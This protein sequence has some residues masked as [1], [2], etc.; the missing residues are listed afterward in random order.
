MCFNEK[1]SLF[2]YLTGLS[3]S[4]ALFSINKIPESL[5]YGWVVHMQLIEYFLWKN[6]P[7][8]I[9][10]Q[11]KI[12]KAEE[13]KQCNQ[14]NKTVSTL[15]IIVNHL[16]PFVLFGS[17]LL[18]SNRKLPLFVMIFVCIFMILIFLYTI[19]IFNKNDEN[20]LCTTVSEESNPHLHWKWNG[21][22]FNSVIYICFL[23]VLMLLSYYGLEKGIIN[24]FM[25]LIG[26]LLSYYIY[27]DKHAVGAMWCFAAAFAPWILYFIY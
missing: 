17:I 5:F 23:I 3:G 27:K 22:I 6:Q 9:T 20:N 1:V 13:I 11:N 12:C 7:C 26:Y 15:G 19:N 24:T 14:T 10:E 21:E 4:A 18:F 25:V 8:Q 2:T 16:E